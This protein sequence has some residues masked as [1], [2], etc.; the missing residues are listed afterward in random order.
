MNKETAY[1]RHH[2][3]KS[4][5][6]RQYAYLIGKCKSTGTVMALTLEQYIELRSQPCHYC[7]HKLPDTGY[8]L[9]RKDGTVGYTVGNTVPCCTV[10][11]FTKHSIWSY[12]EYVEIAKVVSKLLDRRLHSGVTS[13][14]PHDRRKHT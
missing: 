13:T 14:F 7:G 2:N 10:C 11:N 9:D 4:Q 1:K 5:P 12:E 8:C 3:Y 6:Q